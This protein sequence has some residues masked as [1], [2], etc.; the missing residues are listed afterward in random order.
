VSESRGRQRPLRLTSATRSS[1]RRSHPD[2]REP[3][4]R[5]HVA[6]GGEGHASAT[7]GGVKRATGADGA[8]ADRRREAAAPDGGVDRA[9]AGTGCGKRP[10]A[11]KCGTNTGHL[12][13]VAQ[14]NVKFRQYRNVGFKRMLTHMNN[15]EVKWTR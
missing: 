6:A 3:R 14:T 11:V 15:G 2:V 13:G 8:A 10:A 12:F 7:A 5:F 4:Y 9:G 1:F